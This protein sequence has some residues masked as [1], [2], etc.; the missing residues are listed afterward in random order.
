MQGFD[1]RGHF[2]AVAR[3]S[4][5]LLVAVLI[6]FVLISPYFMQFASMKVFEHELV[7][8]ASAQLASQ[9]TC[10]PNGPVVISNITLWQN[11]QC[12]HSGEITING[13]GSLTM[14]NSS[15]VQEVVNA[16]PSD[17][18]LSDYAALTMTSSTVNLGGIGALLVSGNASAS[19]ATSGVV[20]GSIVLSNVGS[21][22]ANSS[23]L[24][25][26]NGLNSTSIASIVVTD[27]TVDVT[28]QSFT[29]IVGTTIVPVVEG[30][31]V[32]MTGNGSLEFQDS[33]FQASNSSLVQLNTL[34]TLVL[35]SV[36]SNYNITDFSLGNS[37]L[38][39]SQTTI[40]DSKVSSSL[41]ANVTIGSPESNS[42]TEIFSSNVLMSD[43]YT[44]NVF[45]YG[46]AALTVDNS[47]VSADVGS[48]IEAFG[49]LLL[50]G[51]IISIL[52]SSVSSSTYD[53]YGYSSLAASNLVV[54]STLYFQVVSS[55]LLSGQNS[56]FGLFADSH[57][58]LNSGANMTISGTSIESNA[59][60]NNSILVRSSYPPNFIHNMTLNQDS[61]V[62]GPNPSN[63]TLSSG[64]GLLLNGTTVTTNVNS[65]LGIDTYQLTSY[66]SQIPGNIT[67]GSTV[68]FAYLY[69]TTVNNVVGLKTGTYQNFEWLYVHV[70]SSNSTG[71]SVP[72]A[73]VSLVDPND[74]SIDYSGT[75]NSSGWAKISVLQAESNASNSV[76]RTYYVV[77]AQQGGKLSNEAYITTNNTSY[78]TLLL[79]SNSA[80]ESS[81]NYF[82]YVLQDQGGTPVSY[83]GIYTNSY[84]LNFVNNATYSEVDFDTVGA[85]GTNY[86]FVLVYPDNFTSSP[87]SVAVDQV[88]LTDVKI[89]SNATCYF[90]SFSIPSGYDQ[91]ALTYI[92]PSTAGSDFYQSPILDP[93]LSVIAA[94]M[95]L[96]I[97]GTVFIFYYVKRQNA[98]SK[99]A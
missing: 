54:N 19:L 2:M 56:Q 8:S 93:G 81:L 27:S 63:I 1:Y 98:L 62:S 44:Q 57:L 91:V 42:T 11:L 61:I 32:N 48:T 76:N 45:I 59:L 64:Y 90:A 47:T 13:T 96:L 5:G 34:S 38:D 39:N 88:P 26:V 58:I 95:L 23:S 70:V 72:G 99:P 41:T 50:Y 77:Q 25:D 71:S 6:I 66:N 31:P 86:T 10:F 69:N 52:G 21:L 97:V 7:P 24:I 85:V 92:S 75:T 60:T 37:S 84:P 18:N 36:I 12:I 9:G 79:D 30:G 51:G 73:I 43:A 46:T 67:V 87:L 29:F 3:M 49:T 89:T 35:N 74:T 40:E 17:L 15:L 22:T 33:T 68:A 28:S 4:R 80:T 65:S 14:V 82:T 83:M 20:N 78:V 55:T 94:V 16:T 53:Y